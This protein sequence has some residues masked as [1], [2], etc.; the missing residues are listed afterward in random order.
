M[1]VTTRPQDNGFVEVDDI[2][3]GE[4]FEWH[5]A[6]YIRPCKKIRERA[7]CCG[8]NLDSGKF[9]VHAITRVRPV[10]MEVREL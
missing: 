1:K 2:P 10:E 8:I 4:T 7:G 9:L 6:Y 3:D 5:G